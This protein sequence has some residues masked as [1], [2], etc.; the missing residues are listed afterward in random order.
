[1]QVKQRVIFSVI[2]TIL[3]RDWNLSIAVNCQKN[4]NP[5]SNIEILILWDKSEIAGYA[6]YK[7]RGKLEFGYPTPL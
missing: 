4:G 5:D 1:V 2:L 7:C 3:R 6:E